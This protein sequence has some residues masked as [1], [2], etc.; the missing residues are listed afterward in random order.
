MRLRLPSLPLRAWMTVSHLMVLALPVLAAVVSGALAREL[1][2]QTRGQVTAQARAIAHITAPA[3][4]AGDTEAI[5]ALAPAI[6]GIEEDSRSRVE[7]LDAGARVVLG[8]PPRNNPLDLMDRAEVAQALVGKHAY[9]VR[10][11]PK[12]CEAAECRGLVR[13]FVAVPVEHQGD[14]IGAVRV[15][16][17][18]ARAMHSIWVVGWPLVLAVGL[19]LLTTIALALVSAHIL[20]R[21]LRSLSRTSHRIRD[22]AWGAVGELARPRRSHVAEVGELSQDI[23]SMTERLQ[24]RLG[25]IS[26]FAGNVSHEFKTPITTLRGTVELLRDD[27]DMEPAQRERFLANAL[28]DLERLERLVSGL[29]ALARA[30][31]GGGS[32]TVDLDAVITD[33]LQGYPGVTREGRAGT[34]RGDPA[35]LRVVLRNLVDNAHNHGGPEVTVRVTARREPGHAVIEVHDDGPGISQANLPRVFDRFFTTGRASGRAGLGLAMVRAIVR[36][37]GGEVTV[38]SEP[39]ATRFVVRVPLEQAP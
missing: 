38:T 25:Y 2:L 39:G 10:R 8:S 5:A 22:G 26:E 14:V 17:A 34:V 18:P 35:Q 37:H 12:G 31:E 7:L 28:A 4:A 32:D 9:T 21:S 24:E 20:S 15:S 19:S 36:S 11:R 33:L 1:E 16:Q 27:N 30:E 23:T 3:L 29:L 6:A 13:V